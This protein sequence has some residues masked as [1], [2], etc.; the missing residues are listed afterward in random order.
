MTY[1]LFDLVNS[2]VSLLIGAGI[3]V[4]VTFKIVTQKPDN[5]QISGDDSQQQVS[6]NNS[7]QN[8]TK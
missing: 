5:D 1:E 2:V 7:N 4:A 6:G 8:Q 3:G